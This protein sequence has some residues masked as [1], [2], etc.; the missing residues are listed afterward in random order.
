MLRSS[1]LLALEAYTRLPSPVQG[2]LERRDEHFEFSS[3]IA[4]DQSFERALQSIDVDVFCARRMRIV[5]NL[6][7]P[8]LVVEGPFVLRGK[9][10]AL[11]NCI[12]GIVSVISGQVPGHLRSDTNTYLLELRDDD[13]IAC[14]TPQQI[15]FGVNVVTDSLAPRWNYISAIFLKQIPC[16]I[17]ACPNGVFSVR[18][19]P[20]K[21]SIPTPAAAKELLQNLVDLDLVVQIETSSPKIIY[22]VGFNCI[23]VGD[24]D[25]RAHVLELQRALR[26]PSIS[27][28]PTLLPTMLPG[29]SIDASLLQA[30]GPSVDLE[31]VKA[32]SPPGAKVSQESLSKW[33]H[34]PRTLLFH[35]SLQKTRQQNSDASSPLFIQLQ[36]GSNRNT[37]F[38]AT[39]S[40]RGPRFRDLRPGESEALLQSQLSSLV[41]TAVMVTLKSLLPSD[42]SE[43]KL[44]EVTEDLN[45][46][47]RKDV[48]ASLLFSEDLKIS[49]TTNLEQTIDGLP[50]SLPSG[51][52]ISVPKYSFSTDSPRL[53]AYLGIFSSLGLQGVFKNWRD[54]LKSEMLVL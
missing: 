3:R 5:R 13:I 42:V 44:K 9:S 28:P 30:S 2:I 49:V 19:S 22:R 25:A 37:N 51:E 35:I 36:V 54:A 27:E 6:A 43:K 4:R 17:I 41:K 20:S 53:C 23:L 50:T 29:F 26:L 14:A 38:K 33:W 11:E 46:R 45:H 8:T 16:A 15:P 47:L 10:V 24:E 7:E 21:S 40:L 31:A 34:A 48:N 12:Q 52:V 1:V 32:A 39:A 18:S